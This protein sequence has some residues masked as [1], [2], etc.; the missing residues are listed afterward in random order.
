MYYSHFGLSG[1]PFGFEPSPELVYLSAGHREAVAGLEWGL[2]EPSGFTLLVGEVGT[3]KTTLISSLLARRHEGVQLAWIPHPRLSF[4]EMLRLVLAQLGLKPVADTKLDLLQSLQ[5]HLAALKPG[6][7]VALI[8]DEAQGLSDELLEE[9]RLLSNL[10][11]QHGGGLQIL[12]VGQLELLRR[13]QS[14]QLATL[15]Q[16]IG[17]RVLLPTLKSPEV[18]DY[19]D[20]RL[21]GVSGDAEKIFQRRALQL[22]VR[23]CGGIPRQ[24]NL[25]CH[26]AFLFAYEQGAELVSAEHMRLAARDYYRLLD[27]TGAKSILFRLT[28]GVHSVS[29][30]REKLIK[31]LSLGA[32]AFLVTAPL[33]VLR[34]RN[35]GHRHPIEERQVRQ[36]AHRNHDDSDI[37]N[38]H[39]ASE[40]APS[41]GPQLTNERDAVFARIGATA[42]F[43]DGGAA[44]Q[45][46]P[47]SVVPASAEILKSPLSPAATVPPHPSSDEKSA[48]S[49]VAALSTVIVK[50][51][52]SLSSLAKRYLGSEEPSQIRT[53]L[54]ANPEIK[55][56]NMIH[57]FQV[58]RLHK[59][60][61]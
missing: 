48:E 24:I 27:G 30:P 59:P 23:S 35:V 22:L 49:K 28:E 32:C 1:P 55:D 13:L 16:R 58:L 50:Q 8:I 40:R 41:R 60:G 17:A 38:K 20:Y 7:R 26:N 56:P 18:Y 54:A 52:D 19:V 2:R 12:L 45:A 10:Q 44:S 6:E 25:L 3:G 33:L 37:L 15:N 29:F 42:P 43:S 61:G 53:L 57:P 14:P 31:V 47:A 11:L 51:G 34:G 36:T 9:L 21:R 46:A 5:A 4:N 39:R